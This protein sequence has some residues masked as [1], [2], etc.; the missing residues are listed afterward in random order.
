MGAYRI[1]DKYLS[2]DHNMGIVIMMKYYTSVYSF[3][4][5]CENKQRHIDYR[6]TVKSED[7]LYSNKPS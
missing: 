6:I 1:I 5:C 4:C 2:N 3:K 7:T